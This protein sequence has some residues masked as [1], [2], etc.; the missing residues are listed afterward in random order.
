[1]ELAPPLPHESVA[2]AHNAERQ[3]AR[4]LDFYGVRWEYEPQTFVLE[5]DRDGRPTMGFTPDFYLPAYD[6]F[7]EVTTLSQK[8]VTKKNAKVRRLRELHPEIQ[9]KI[10]YQ[11]D[12]VA[13]LEKYGL[14]DPEQWGDAERSGSPQPS[15]STPRTPASGIPIAS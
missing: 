15:R 2:F 4:L 11:R 5:W 14:E 6:L 7:I 1:V 13:L 10:L 9:V 12:Y 8:L 3:L